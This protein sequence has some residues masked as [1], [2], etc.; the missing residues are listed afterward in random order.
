VRDWRRIPVE[1]RPDNLDDCAVTWRSEKTGTLPWTAP[2]FAVPES[3]WGP[4]LTHRPGDLRAVTLILPSQHGQGLQ[5]TGDDGETPQPMILAQGIEVGQRQDLTLARIVLAFPAEEAWTC[6]INRTYRG[7]S[8][9]RHPGRTFLTPKY[10]L[11]YDPREGF[12]LAQIPGK[13]Q[14]IAHRS[15]T[16][17]HR[18]GKR[19]LTD[20]ELV[21]AWEGWIA[22][23]PHPDRMPSGKAADPDEADLARALWARIRGLWQTA[24]GRQGDRLF[25]MVTAIPEIENNVWFLITKAKDDK[26]RQAG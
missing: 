23:H 8:D 22:Q 13:A 6:W 2:L 3:T 15:G 4:Y 20:A 14:V 9:G 19:I 24:T 10:H 16:V 5:V 18:G 21:A 26:P 1:V 7:K 12:A 25:A 17:T 11:A